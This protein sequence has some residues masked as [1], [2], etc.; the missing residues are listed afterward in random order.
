MAVNTNQF[1][2]AFYDSATDTYIDP[3]QEYLKRLAAQQN[4][5]MNNAFQQQMGL[6][7][8]LSQSKNPQLQDQ[9][10]APKKQDIK[11]L[12]LEE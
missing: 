2:R 10:S 9:A 3:Q 4:A 12:L 6:S 8:A 5:A 1:N 11:L 7:N